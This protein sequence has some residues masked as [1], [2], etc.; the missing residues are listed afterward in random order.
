MTAAVLP[1]HDFLHGELPN[2]ETHFRLLRIIS[3][4]VAELVEDRVPAGSSVVSCELTTWS[5]ADAPPYYAVSYTWGDRW[6]T[7]WI[8]V[9]REAMRVRW[10]CA[11]L[12]WQVYRHSGTDRYIW[13]DAICI[14]QR[15]NREKS[16][17]VAR[18]GKIFEKAERVLACIGP[19][20]FYSTVVFPALIGHS[21]FL[22]Q[23]S[24]LATKY[25]D[26]AWHGGITFRIRLSRWRSSSSGTRE[27][28]RSMTQVLKRPYFQRVWTW[29]ELWLAQSVDILCGRDYAPSRTL[30]G[31]RTVMIPRPGQSLVMNF[32]DTIVAWTLPSTKLRDL[33]SRLFPERFDGH[34]H[35]IG[36]EFGAKMDMVFALQTTRRLNCENARDRVY[37]MIPITYRSSSEDEP[38]R[39]DYDIDL[40][41]L[42]IKV[43]QLAIKSRLP[44]SH[45]KMLAVVE[46]LL[47]DQPTS[48]KTT[49]AIQD[50]R[51][52]NTVRSTTWM[53]VE[54]GLAVGRCALP[55][56]GYQLRVDNDGWKISIPLH[57]HKHY[58]CPREHNDKYKTTSKVLDALKQP[59]YLVTDDANQPYAL[60]PTCAEPGDWIVGDADAGF[61]LLR[62]RED[63]KYKVVG[64][65]RAREDMHFCS[66]VVGQVFTV[67][68][69][70]G[71]SLVLYLDKFYGG[72]HNGGFDSLLELDTIASS[73]ENAI[74]YTEG[75]SYA[76]IG[77]TWRA[78]GMTELRLGG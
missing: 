46:G 27:L 62:E 26:I 48:L 42:A 55:F 11:Y 44:L 67:F 75:S 36:K 21:K 16:H 71:D 10:N 47:Q 34:M 72:Y 1:R 49:R 35:A 51:H 22:T 18:M 31:L 9:N 53:A 41:D 54:D 38:I 65:A 37:S 64:E 23:A 25:G 59:H 28:K 45:R 14:N 68:F 20:D 74:C 63:G 61:I 40:F 33:Y 24:M 19:H 5:L 70:P 17:Q 29:P 66:A 32:Y 15:D 52:A 39:P 4:P 3:A 60:L 7:I 57:E 76:E 2:S 50:R 13:V 69:E 78:I 73:L 30:H 12:L 58:K 43:L 8:Q 6:K 56:Y 77:Y